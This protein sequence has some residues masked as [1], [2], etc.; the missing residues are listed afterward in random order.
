MVLSRSSRN[1]RLWAEVG[2][3]FSFLC[4]VDGWNLALFLGRMHICDLAQ[5]A[6]G[7]DLPRIHAAL[8]PY[9]LYISYIIFVFGILLS[10]V[11]SPGPAVELLR[12]PDGTIYLF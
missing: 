3:I 12:S 8:E 5:L 7:K 11:P 9:K 2:L 4:M 10:G 6:E 1:A